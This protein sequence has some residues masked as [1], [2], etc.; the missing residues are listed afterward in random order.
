METTK[1]LK[2]KSIVLFN[3]IQTWSNNTDA[4]RKERLYKSTLQLIEA[5][6]YLDSDETLG[7]SADTLA[8]NLQSYTEQIEALTL[9]E[10]QAEFRTASSIAF[11]DLIIKIHKSIGWCS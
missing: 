11:R 8:D 10:L 7:L 4:S 6:E 3:P 9:K 1:L 5:K 2:Q